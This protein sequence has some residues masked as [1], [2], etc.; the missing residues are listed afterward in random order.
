MKRTFFTR[1]VMALPMVSAVVVA[2][3]LTAPRPAQACP[4]FP[5]AASGINCYSVF[6]A[7]GITS[8]DPVQHL[9]LTL[10]YWNFGPLLYAVNQPWITTSVSPVATEPPM[11]A[12]PHPSEASDAGHIVPPVPDGSV[13]TPKEGAGVVKLGPMSTL[14]FLMG[15]PPEALGWSGARDADLP[16][17]GDDGWTPIDPPTYLDLDSGGDPDIE[18]VIPDLTPIVTI[19]GK[20]SPDDRLLAAYGP[21]AA[22]N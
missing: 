22:V 9:A 1:L 4:G 16:A 13:T 17:K 20:D 7:R 12:G 14:M 21:P 15:V 8:L 3:S 19:A 2:V 10:F 6:V 18:S 11:P 5:D